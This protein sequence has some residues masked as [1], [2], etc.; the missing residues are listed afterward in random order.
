[1]REV[2][3]YVG[4]C[5]GLA[6]AVCKQGGTAVVGARSKNLEQAKLDEKRMGIK[7]CRFKEPQGKEKKDRHSVD[8]QREEG[9]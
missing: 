8:N 1:M 9:E 6:A 4:L 2:A 7:E 5:R 3:P